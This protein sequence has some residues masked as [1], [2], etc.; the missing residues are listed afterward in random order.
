MIVP[1]NKKGP[2]TIPPADWSKSNGWVYNG[3]IFNTMT[4]ILEQD[5]KYRIDMDLNT[6][7]CSH[8]L[9]VGKERVKLEI[10]PPEGAVSVIQFKMPDALVQDNYYVVY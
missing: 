10:K 2:G 7:R 4:T 8:P 5:E 1:A 6:F 3:I 9:P